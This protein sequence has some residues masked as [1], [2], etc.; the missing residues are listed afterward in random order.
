MKNKKWAI[1]SLIILVVFLLAAFFFTS[2][3]NWQNNYRGKIYPGITVGNIDLSGKT[4][5]EAENIIGKKAAEITDSGLTFVYNGKA[6]TIGASVSSFD[7]DLSYPSLIFD[8]KETVA[9][10]QTQ[11]K[12]D[13]Y[14]G[15]LA[16]T[17]APKEKKIL[18]PVYLLDEARL[19]PLLDEAFPELIIAPINSSFSLSEETGELTAEQ[20]KLGKEINYDAAF[21]ELKDNLN[22]FAN[23]PINLKTR[24]KYPDVKSA[25]LSV[26]EEEAKKI[27]DAG[28]LSINFKDPSDKSATTTWKI[29]PERLL[30]WLGAVREDGKVSLSLNRD[31]V[32]DYLSLN[33]SPEVDREAVR[34]RFEIKNGKV[35][36]WQAGANGRKINISSST[37]KISEAFL[38]GEKEIY[39]EAEEIISENLD[40]EKNLNIKEIIGTGHSNFVGSSANRIKNIKTGAEAVSGILIAPSEEFSLVKVLGD[41]DAENGY[42]PELVIKG[43]KTVKEYGGGLC[44]IGTTVFRAAIQSGLPI[45]YRRN[46]SYRV[47]YY[48]PAG[49]DAAIYIPEPDVRFINDTANYILIQSRISG[50]DI[51]FD[52]WG[53]ND[54]REVTITEPVIYNIVKPSP[55]KYVETTELEPGVEKCTESAHNG[56][57]AYFDY[58][59]VY[60]ENS[61]TTPI[62]ER[63]FSSHYV[64]WQKVCLVGAEKK[65][66]ENS[67]TDTGVNTNEVEPTTDSSDSNPATSTA[68]DT[69]N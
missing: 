2:F 4:A 18:S 67:E 25:D 12:N 54:G 17:L 47:S 16:F 21:T 20:E 37:E 11:T 33:V 15:Y 23:R 59:V 10:A 61:T 9:R 52:F 1:K 31:K 3:R 60:P 43:D 39:L 27:I 7:T 35:A 64:P 28:A 8:V 65:E 56:A 48:E 68:S 45:T 63:R 62:H 69:A 38:S 44:Q 13:S 57:D 58:K 24:S 46:H 30:G 36:S 14:F 32:A 22:V 50:N 34:P 6:K 66:V 51:Y 5:A 55:T 40:S 49:M 41:V 19:K 26:L 53:V 42:Y 29:K